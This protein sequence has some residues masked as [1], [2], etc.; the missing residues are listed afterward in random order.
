MKCIVISWGVLSGIGKGITG[1]SIWALIRSAWYNVFMQK[2][3][4]YLNVDPGTMNPT[5]HGEVF[6][7]EDGTE[8]D[9]DLGHYERFMDID[10]NKYSSR[11]SGKIY[12]EIISNERNGNYL[13]QTVQIIPHVTDMIKQKVHQGWEQSWAD[14]CIIEIGWTVGDMENEIM[15]EAMRQ[16]RHELGRDHIVFVHLSYIPYLLASK[17]LKTKPTQSSVKQLQSMGISPDFLITRADCA[18]DEQTIQK[19]S[20]MCWL[21]LDHVIPAPTV[22]SIYQIPLDYRN[23]KLGELILDQFWLS[24]INGFELKKRE[25]LYANIQESKANIRI[26]MVGKYTGLEDAYY[27]LNEGLKLAWFNNHHRVKLEFIDAELIEKDGTGVLDGIDWICIPGGFGSRWIEGMI[28]AAQYAREQDIPFLGICLGSQ[29][30]AIE[31]ARHVLG[32]RDAT[33]EEFDE[34]NQSRNHVIHIMES[35]KQ[36]QKKG[37]SM[38]LGS[39]PCMLVSGSKVAKIYWSEN[40]SERH[41]HRY[42]FNNEYRK[43]FQDNGF[44]ISWTSP[45]QELVEMVELK[46]HTFML[47][48][49]A[50]PELKSRPTRIHPLFDGFIKAIVAKL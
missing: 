19:I 5:Q 1:A 11:T 38:R 46:D 18:I 9:L 24:Y 14:I 45:D 35:Q 2:L 10:L 22:E 43:Q 34:N 33:S 12:E 3:D 50:H 41:R 42:E 25:M 48:T 13:G 44:L 7:M 29:I 40:I 49:Q 6:V 27:S 4:G 15:F 16:L 47:A 23:H 26:A 37:G 39:Y 31:F 17:E 36:I 28:I 21:P 8:A 20:Y 32:I 30:M